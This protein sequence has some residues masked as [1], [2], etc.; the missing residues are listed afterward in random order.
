MCCLGLAT[1]LFNNPGCY[2]TIVT[3]WLGAGVSPVSSARYDA[4][5]LCKTLHYSQGKKALDLRLSDYNR[6]FWKDPSKQRT[7][8][9][10]GGRSSVLQRLVSG[11]GSTVLP[12]KTLL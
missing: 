9:R 6:L 4:E 12:N 8:R 10:R 5:M 2:L 7:I 1:G 3:S 11:R